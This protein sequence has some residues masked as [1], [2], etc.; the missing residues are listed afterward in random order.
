MLDSGL[1]LPEKGLFALKFMQRG[2][3]KRKAAAKQMLHDLEEQLL[4]DREPAADDDDGND[5]DDENDKAFSKNSAKKSSAGVSGRRVVG[6]DKVKASD[7][8][9]KDDSKNAEAEVEEE[10]EEDDDEPAFLLPVINT[11]P[12]QAPEKKSESKPKADK[13]SDAAAPEKK[14]ESKPKADKRSDAAAPEKKSESKPKADKRSAATTTATSAATT[15]AKKSKQ[16]AKQVV[17]DDDDEDDHVFSIGNTFAA[18]L[19]TIDGGATATT[20][21]SFDLSQR[22]LV[23]QAFAADNV[24]V[25]DFEREKAALVDEERPKDQDVT[26]PGWVRGKTDISFLCLCSSSLSCLLRECGVDRGSDPARSVLSSLRPRMS[27]RE[28]TTSSSTSSSTRSRM[29]RR[30]S[31]LLRASPTSSK[32]STTAP[33][34]TGPTLFLS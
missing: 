22:D 12:Q 18:Q 5:D 30:P 31:L 7:R 10:D 9:Q 29:P 4:A 2:L 3:E 33:R 8:N 27:S 1:E 19:Q 24:L 34:Y 32:P 25:E 20:L 26:L 15:T 16:P 13:R 17:E 11:K 28:R 23:A 6:L 21:P 14:S